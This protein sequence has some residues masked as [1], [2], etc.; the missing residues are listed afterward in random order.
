MKHA[1][2]SPCANCP[3]LKTAPLALWDRDEYLKL[4]DMEEREG[5]PSVSSMFMCHKGGRLP[6]KEREPCVGWLLNQRS[7]NV[8]SIALRLAL[9]FSEEMQSQFEQLE[10]LERCYETVAEL[11]KINLA[12]DDTM[13]TLCAIP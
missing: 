8:P 5:D 2:T 1:S 10:G 11:V 9:G 12:A 4:S 7:R 6:V 13:R 3:F